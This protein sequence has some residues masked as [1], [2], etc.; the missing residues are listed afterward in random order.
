MLELAT[1]APT[2]R[3]ASGFRGDPL[4]FVVCGLLDESCF[5]ESEATGGEGESMVVSG[6]T[7]EYEDE[8]LVVAAPLARIEDALLV[9]ELSEPTVLGM[10]AR[11]MSTSST[12]DRA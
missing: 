5:V 4:V 10:S 11:S 8:F 6:V 2:A 3:R 12:A 7:Y 9:F 1:A